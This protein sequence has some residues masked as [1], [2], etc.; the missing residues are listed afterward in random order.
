MTVVEFNGKKLP[1][2]ISK[3]S[4]IL[5]INHTQR[6]ELKSGSTDGHH[7]CANRTDLARTNGRKQR[8]SGAKCRNRK[9]TKKAAG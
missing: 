6:S 7:R 4:R 2:Y 5:M 9:L 8:R 1:D 3:S